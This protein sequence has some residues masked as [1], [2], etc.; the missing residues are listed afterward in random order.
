MSRNL[1]LLCLDLQSSYHCHVL[2]FLHLRNPY[3]VGSSQ[4]FLEPPA[5]LHSHHPPPPVWWPCLHHPSWILQPRSP[6]QEAQGTLG[7]PEPSEGM[8]K[9]AEWR[10]VVPLGVGRAW[11]WAEPRRPLGTPSA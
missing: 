8:L 2:Y 5:P 3:L 4:G 11:A 9:H 1:F 7:V 10:P 6:Q